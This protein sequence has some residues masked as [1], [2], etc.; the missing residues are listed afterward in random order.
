MKFSQ[1]IIVVILCLLSF[2]AGSQ[3]SENSYYRKVV[4]GYIVLT[5][6]MFSDKTIELTYLIRFYKMNERSPEEAKDYLKRIIVMRY[7]PEERFKNAFGES[8]GSEDKL[9][10]M[11]QEIKEFLIDNPLSECK[12]SP[13]EQVLQ[14]HLDNFLPKG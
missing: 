14:C 1:I 7:T 4:E 10:I 8:Y 3:F 2:I 9:Y 13:K 12:E 6:T 5:E 11:N